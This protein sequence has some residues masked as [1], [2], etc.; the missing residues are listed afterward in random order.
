MRLSCGAAAFS[1][2]HGGPCTIA[3]RTWHSPALRSGT[4]PK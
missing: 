2:W 3:G 4:F 1:T